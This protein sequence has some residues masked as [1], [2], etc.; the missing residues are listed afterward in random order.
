MPC[1]FCK[2]CIMAAEQ[3]QLAY[4]KEIVMRIANVGGKCI[5]FS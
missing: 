4:I 2:E 3:P 5:D 1:A